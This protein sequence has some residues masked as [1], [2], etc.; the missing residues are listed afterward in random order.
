M[1]HPMLVF[2]KHLPDA[3]TNQLFRFCFYH[4]FK[5]YLPEMSNVTR[6]ISMHFLLNLFACESDVKRIYHD[7]SI[8]DVL[9]FIRPIYRFVFARN[10]LCNVLAHLSKRNSGSVVKV[11]DL[12]IFLNWKVG[13]SIALQFLEISHYFVDFFWE[14]RKVVNLSR[15]FRVQFR[16]CRKRRVR[17]LYRFRWFKLRNVG[18]LDFHP[19]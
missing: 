18:K 14:F 5:G 11:K 4:P 7:T 1:L 6:M 3:P 2:R 16:P 19:V 13:S 17:V 15:V 10:M 8:P 9:L 12:A